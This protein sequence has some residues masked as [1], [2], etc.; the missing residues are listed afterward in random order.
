MTVIRK[1]ELPATPKPCL[2][3]TPDVQKRKLRTK[4]AAFYVGLSA[5]TMEKRR[6]YGNGP[7][8]TKLGRVVVYDTADLDAWVSA[9]TRTS[10]SDLGA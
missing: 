9:N 2:P 5:S 3:P 7:R 10:T 8:Y 4:E 1:R 6:V